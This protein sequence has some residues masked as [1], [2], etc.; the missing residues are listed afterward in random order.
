MEALLALAH[1]R[2]T[3]NDLERARE[4]AER[5]LALAEPAKAPAMLAGG[6]VVLG[7]K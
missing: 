6:H 4:L 1:A 7:L 5:V 2:L 3:R